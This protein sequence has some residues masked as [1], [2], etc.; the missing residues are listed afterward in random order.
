MA[1][2]VIRIFPPV[3]YLLIKPVVKWYLRIFRL[4]IKSDYAQYKKYCNAL[5][6]ADPWKLKKAVIA[7]SKYEVWN[8][9]GEIEYPTLIIGASK[10]VLHE[11]ENL[12]KMVFMMKNATYNDLE[13][14]KLT[15]SVAMVEEMRKF[16]HYSN[17][18][19]LLS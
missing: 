15:H 17:N 4:D 8:L 7:L 5:D 1:M 19:N 2:F 14:N 11:P 10:D 9:L 3:F 18:A 13:T 12:H 6:A 16:R